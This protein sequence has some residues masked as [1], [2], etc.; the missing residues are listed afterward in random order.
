MIYFKDSQDNTITTATPGNIIYF[1]NRPLINYG[2]GLS[3]KEGDEVI[4]F[5][6]EN[7]EKLQKY[8]SEELKKAL[9][10]SLENMKD[11]TLMI[12]SCLKRINELEEE[13]VKL[14]RL[15][16][17]LTKNIMVLREGQ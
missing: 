2:P 12:E 6:K 9:E 15:N 14:K 13:N 4:I 5:T 11:C 1:H 16:E 17:Q 8:H 7:L 10:N 3:H